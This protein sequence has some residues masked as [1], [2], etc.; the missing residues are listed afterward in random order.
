MSKGLKHLRR[1]EVLFAYLSTDTCLQTYTAWITF[2]CVKT[3]EMSPSSLH[4]R[5]NVFHTPSST[6]SALSPESC[7][8]TFWDALSVS[9]LSLHRRHISPC[10]PWLLFRRAYCLYIAFLTRVMQ[11]WEQIWRVC[12]YMRHI[13]MMHSQHCHS[14]LNHRIT[15]KSTFCSAH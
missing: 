10:I 13:C 3:N 2:C 8:H 5:W 6:E 11:R 14:F 12:N 7:M 4:R 1:N 15:F 9:V